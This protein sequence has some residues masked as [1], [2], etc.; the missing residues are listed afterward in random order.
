M[1]F[2][3][4][5]S[6]P[7]V[8]V[9]LSRTVFSYTGTHFQ[10]QNTSEISIA[11]PSTFFEIQSFEKNWIFESDVFVKIREFWNLETLLKYV[12]TIWCEA[13]VLFIFWNLS[14]SFLKHSSCTCSV[15]SHSIQIISVLF[16]IMC[17]NQLNKNSDAIWNI[18]RL[19]SLPMFTNK[20]GWN[21]RF[22]P[23]FWLGCSTDT[24]R[25]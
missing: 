12:V 2:P 8:E 9:K 25:P 19:S 21:Q 5:C 6:Q 11:K 14:N 7:L 4:D 23:S 17:K 16:V 18:G 24:Q 3:K 20:T 13:H 1:C 22:G 10:Q 15:V